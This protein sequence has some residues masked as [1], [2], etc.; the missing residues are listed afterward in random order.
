VKEKMKRMK[1]GIIFEV[2][3][4]NILNLFI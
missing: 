3:F 2:I 1:M 4:V